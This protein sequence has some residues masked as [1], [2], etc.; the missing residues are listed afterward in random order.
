MDLDINPTILVAYL[1]SV[2]HSVGTGV[3]LPK[4]TAGSSKR[5][6]SPNKSSKVEKPKVV[7]EVVKEVVTKLVTEPVQ[8]TIVQDVHTEV[9]PSKT[10]ILKRTKNPAHRPLH[11]PDPR[12]IIEDVAV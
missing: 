11:S 10:G 12:P 5:G 9:V 4:E 2:N 8:E 6:K 7:P 3:L 1:Q